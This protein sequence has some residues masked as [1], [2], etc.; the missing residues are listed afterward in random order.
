MPSQARKNNATREA[1]G[2]LIRL[3]ETVDTSLVRECLEL[4]L[5]LADALEKKKAGP[6][7]TVSQQIGRAHFSTLAYGEHPRGSGVAVIPRS[8][9][10]SGHAVSGQCDGAALSYWGL[11]ISNTAGSGD[12]LPIH[13]PAD[14]AAP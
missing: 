1:L 6:P 11:C 12:L 3:G 4:I 14:A 10:Q 9:D 2:K 8:T 13:L 5:M 7:I